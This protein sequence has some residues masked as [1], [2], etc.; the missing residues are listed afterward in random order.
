[1]SSHKITS[2]RDLALALRN[3]YFRVNQ[4]WYR[5]LK[6]RGLSTLEFVQF[7]VHQNRFADIRKCPDMPPSAAKDYA[8]EPGELVPPVGPTYLLH[9]FKH[10][11]DYDGELIT[12]LRVPKKSGRLSLGVGWGIHLVEGFLPDRVWMLLS[13]LFALASLVFGVLWAWKKHDVQGA[14][15][16]AAWICG[17]AVLSVG[18]LQAGL[19]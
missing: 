12:Y 3:H 17:L 19:G 15:G 14:F 6:L 5:T 1:M 11:E 4:K 16:V 9:L 18:W 2:D 13:G 10:P 8:F 7:E